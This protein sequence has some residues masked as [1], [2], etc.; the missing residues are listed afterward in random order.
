MCVCVCVCVCVCIC[1]LFLQRT[2]GSHVQCQ[3]TSR[4][5]PFAGIAFAA[6][7]HYINSLAIAAVLV[8]VEEDVAPMTAFL[9]DRIAT[10]WTCTTVVRNHL[11]TQRQKKIII[12]SAVSTTQASLMQCESEDIQKK[13]SSD[14]QLARHKQHAMRVGGYIGKSVHRRREAPHRRHLY[15]LPTMP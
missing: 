7:G 13:S 1:T 14:Q 6:G 2:W 15:T 8:F 10:A 11:T 3:R 9:S 5:N 4:N 12:K